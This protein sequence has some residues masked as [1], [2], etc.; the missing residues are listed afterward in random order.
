M[1]VT[2]KYFGE[3]AE[4]MNKNEEVK[5]VEKSPEAFSKLKKQFFS[6]SSLLNTME[7]KIAHNNTI[8]E[9]NVELKEGDVLSFL[10]PFAGG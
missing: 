3:I 9:Q 6:C 7:I 4:I 1:R 8:V 10:P 5:S 2:G